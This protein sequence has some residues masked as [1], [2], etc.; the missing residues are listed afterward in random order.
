MSTN[1]VVNQYRY[2]CTTE[3]NLV[4]KWDT[5]TPTTCPN[6][7]A[8]TID[9]TSM[10]IVD[11]VKSS[12]VEVSNLL[13]NSFDELRVAEKTNIIDLKSVF[14]LTQLRD[15]YSSN[16]TG[17]IGNSNGEYH[18]TVAAANDI[19]QLSS[20][21]R[22][23]YLAGCVGE[24]GIGVRMTVASLSNTQ[25]ARWGYFDSSNGFYF[26]LNSNGLNAAILR[27][28]QETVFPRSQ[29]NVDPL[30]GTG[31]S[32]ATVLASTGHIYQINYSWYGYGVI[33]YTIVAQGGLDT[34]QRNLVAHRHYTS[35]AVSIPNPNLPIRAEL[36]N[37]TT[38]S[39]AQMFIG[40]RQYSVIG[41][42]L[43][44]RRINTSYRST[45]T[46]SSAFAPVISIRRKADYQSVAVKVFSA[47]FIASSDMFVEIRT[48]TTLTGGTWDNIPSQQAGETAM[49]QNT[50]ATAVTGGIVVW[51]GIIPADKASL[52]QVE[53]L[54]YDISEFDIVT[55]AARVI[56][57]SV[58]TFNAALRWSEEW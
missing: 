52:R 18:L 38:A 56:S 17:F 15:I 43:P 29:F 42:Y 34:R 53:G 13:T 10:T 50:T 54:L 4:Y 28:G 58:G 39:N 30:D 55:V 31:P 25:E 36:R 32:K 11:T 26:M 3:S 20:A 19:A 1:R 12:E 35:N 2:Y 37:N 48:K 21:E 33:E 24:V 46:P 22:G 6:D 27:N 8:H 49:E 14:G 40:G 47:D 7:A 5:A 9:A 51:A 57:N 45:P 23:R 16:G 44:N 41:K